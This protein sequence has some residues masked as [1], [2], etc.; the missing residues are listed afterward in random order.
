MKTYT[1][2]SSCEIKYSAFVKPG[3][4]YFTFSYLGGSPVT[5]CTSRKIW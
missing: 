2:K 3:Y 4:H 5:W 1:R